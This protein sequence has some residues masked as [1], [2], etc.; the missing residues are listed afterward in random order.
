M[1][2]AATFLQFVPSL[3]V[4]LGV[5]GAPSSQVIQVQYA[6][7]PIVAGESGELTVRFKIAG[8]F[9]IPKRP[10]P[11]LQLNSSDEIEVAGD[12]IF[13]EEGAGKDPEYFKG[14]RPITLQLSPARTAR[15]GSHMLE[16][17]FVYFYCSEKEKYCSRN[18]ENLKI[19]VEVVDLK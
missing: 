15:R 13:G 2:L 11:R 16:G 18:V 10:F 9:K 8:G 3:F 6:V 5:T 1:R 19:P 14:I 17:K 4:T 7:S 12:V